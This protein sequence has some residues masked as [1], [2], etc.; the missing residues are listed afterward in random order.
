MQ[1]DHLKRRTFLALLGGAGA[2]WPLAAR[3]QQPMM[4][5][6]GFLD[7]RSP[8]AV[9]DRLRA[10]RQGLKE[11]GY[12]EG[13][14]V[15]IAYRFA[16]N[17][18]DRLH[19]LAADLVRRQVAVIATSAEEAALVAKT[20]TRTVPILFTVS[21]DPVS[22]G[23]VA[24]LAHP[25][26]NL[27]GVN[28][29]SGELVA[30]RLELLRELVPQASRVAVLVNPASSAGLRETTLQNAE[31]AAHGM[32]LSVQILNASTSREI[33]AAFATL[34]HDRAGVL[35]V[36]GDPFFNSRRVQ[37]AN[38]AAHHS[39]PMASGSREI[40]E[41]GGLM[42]YGAS[43]LDAYHEVGIYAGRI[44][45]GAKPLDLPVV[46]SSKFELVINAQTARMLGLTIPP[47]LLAT[48][49]EVIE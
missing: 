30:K 16:E 42:S 48:A 2:A 5:V 29:L 7:P 24:S 46:Q 49:D 28:F 20:A 21:R 26:G 35:L 17:Q 19:E 1:F 15:T 39:I 40:A 38:L 27:S 9:T 10:F 47:S 43:I 3:A 31:E 12:I 11:T 4:P 36:G 18:I 23:L 41:A 8:D 32:G 34:A 25:G 13:E 45:K 14:N 44:L 22:L 33:D 37:L 6:V